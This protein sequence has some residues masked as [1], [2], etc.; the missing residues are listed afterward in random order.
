MKT[1][2]KTTLTTTALVIL[3]IGLLTLA[4]VH[5]ALIKER[6]GLLADRATLET[7]AAMLKKS[8]SEQKAQAES[9]L[10]ARQAAEAKVAHANQLLSQQ[11]GEVKELRTEVEALEAQAARQLESDKGEEDQ[12]R[13]AIAQWKAKVEELRRANDASQAKIREQQA[14]IA[15]LD[16][17]VS[18][19][20]AALENETRQHKSCRED[21]ATLAGLGRDLAN[22]YLKKG[23]VDALTTNEPLTQLKKVE[24]EKLIQVYLDKIDTSTLPRMGASHP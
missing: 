7:K 13:E 4:F 10:R 23:V 22:S 16:G 1:K 11:E 9:F 17:L 14:R 15:D 8:Y 18:S 24:M 2:N 3:S 19:T 5:H 6:D 20:K 21:N 12:L